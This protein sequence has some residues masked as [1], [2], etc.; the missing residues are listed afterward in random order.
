MDCCSVAGMHFYGINAYGIIEKPEG[1]QGTHSSPLSL[2]FCSSRAFLIFRHRIL[3]RRRACLHTEQ[4]P[5]LPLSSF[6]FLSFFS[7][8]LVVLFSSKRAKD[9]WFSPYF[10]DFVHLVR[11]H[12]YVPIRQT[13]FPPPHVSISSRTSSIP[14]CRHPFPPFEIPCKQVM[15]RSRVIMHTSPGPHPRVLSHPTPS[16]AM[17]PTIRCIFHFCPAS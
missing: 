8:M 15:S 10:D 14:S 1:S 9:Q 6:F 3:V 12:S 7:Y 17:Y 16:F 4:Q 2:S 13:G 5:P 11:T